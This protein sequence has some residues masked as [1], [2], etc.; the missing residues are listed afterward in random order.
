MTIHEVYM[1]LD[2]LKDYLRNGYDEFQ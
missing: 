2:L 1:H